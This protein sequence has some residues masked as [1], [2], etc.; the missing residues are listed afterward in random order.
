[1]LISAVSETISSLYVL[2]TVREVTANWTVY[3][4]A[5]ALGCISV[6]LAAF[7]PARAAAVMSPSASLHP[8]VESEKHDTISRFWLATGAVTLAVAGACSVLALQTG[9]AWLS[10]VAAFF[11]MASA[12]GLAPFVV[13][14]L[15][16]L[17]RFALRF[18]LEPDIA[19]LNLRRSLARNSVTIAALASAVAM[20]V[21]VGIMIFSF[22]QTVV[23][24]IDQV[25]VADLF[26][27]PAS[28]EIAGPTS[29]LPREVTFFFESHP[30]VKA[31]DTFREIELR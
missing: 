27:T 22:R 23:A 10:F 2:V 5:A 31:L 21:G 19:A 28:N 4:G 3:L 9:P 20:T 26:V 7:V 12:S 25:L 18:R 6:V 16:G 8:E 17:I 15:V 11:C 24:W 1:S 13:S 29:F 14:N 30:A